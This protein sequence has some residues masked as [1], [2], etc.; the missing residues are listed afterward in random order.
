MNTAGGQRL[1][2]AIG[3]VSVPQSFGNP[4]CEVS[5]CQPGRTD[6]VMVRKVRP[7]NGQ[8]N[9]GGIVSRSFGLL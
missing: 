6:C 1:V 7:I 4:T 5:S 8:H 9:F 3:V 2:E